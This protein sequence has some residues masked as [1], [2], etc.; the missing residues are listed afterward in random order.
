M[1]RNKEEFL[2]KKKNTNLVDEMQIGLISLEKSYSVIRDLTKVILDKAI[3]ESAF[4]SGKA[5]GVHGQKKVITQEP[6]NMELDDQDL[7]FK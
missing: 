1:L 4:K 7:Q 6:M 3:E 5:F 2:L